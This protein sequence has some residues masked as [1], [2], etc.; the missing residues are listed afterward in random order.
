[1]DTLPLSMEEIVV[2]GKKM[3]TKQAAGLDNILSNTI[4]IA[5]E[6]AP[7]IILNIMNRLMKSQSFPSQ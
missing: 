1:M 3:K 2:I 5:V 6:V 4:K 7:E